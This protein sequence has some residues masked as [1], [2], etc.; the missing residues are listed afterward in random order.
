VTERF[1]TPVH[2]TAER[3]LM[4]SFKPTT[5]LT[6]EEIRQIASAKFEEAAALPDGPQRQQ[7]LKSAYSFRSLAEMKGWLSSDLQPPS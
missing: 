7:L 3:D 5:Y 1:C 6:I 2:E 4:G